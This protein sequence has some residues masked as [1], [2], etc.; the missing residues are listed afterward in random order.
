MGTRMA[1]G[2]WGL[3]ILLARRAACGRMTDEPPPAYPFQDRPQGQKARGTCA[4]RL[5]EETWHKPVAR[6]MRNL[7][8]SQR[9]RREP[10][11]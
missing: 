9:S 11:W 2:L 3:S 1:Q 6:G 8:E 5:A 10:T 4:V 7:L